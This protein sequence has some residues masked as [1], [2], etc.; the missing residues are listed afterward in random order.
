MLDLPLLGLRSIIRAGA[1]AW[2]FWAFLVL[3][4]ALPLTLAGVLSVWQRRRRAH[5]GEPVRWTRPLKLANVAFWLLAAGLCGWGVLAYIQAGQPVA[6]WISAV[7][8]VYSLTALV[9]LFGILGGWVWTLRASRY[10]LRPE[11]LGI[12]LVLRRM[13][14]SG[15][16]R[17]H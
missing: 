11:A 16:T 10:V 13:R 1:D 14:A 2:S 4:G 17:Q 5:I 6:V 15:L 12:L 8:L 7:L 9:L 3:F